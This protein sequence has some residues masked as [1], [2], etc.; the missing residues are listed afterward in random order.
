M[1]KSR[2]PVARPL[3]LCLWLGSI[4]AI[5]FF[6]FGF[7]GC[8]GPDTFLRKPTG[9]G[10]GGGSSFGTGGHGTGGTLG[11]GGSTGSGG[12]G[13]GGHTGTGGSSG[14][15]GSFGVGGARDGGPDAPGAGGSG[16][17]GAQF[18]G[19]A[20]SE[21]GITQRGACDT[22]CAPTTPVFDIV[23]MG[24]QGASSDKLIKTTG[25]ICL[26]T[27]PSSMVQGVV[28]SSFTAMGGNRMLSINGVLNAA[29]A[30][31]NPAPPKVNGGYCFQISAGVPDYAAIAVF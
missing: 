19:S 5:G 14:T 21:A 20:D 31:P 10:S 23:V 15:G 29:C 6:L 9:G 30:W 17:G 18:D 28:C 8:Q 25:E 27:S 7:A 13:V 24:G 4:A 11:T 3:T 2:F 12:S 16:M 26:A 1:L 22:F